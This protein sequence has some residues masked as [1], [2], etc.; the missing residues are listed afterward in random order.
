MACSTEDID[1][2]TCQIFG[3][4]FVAAKP[5]FL[6]KSIIADLIRDIRDP[7]RP[8]TLEQLNVV[9]ESMIR[10]RSLPSDE[11]EEEELWISISF[12]PTVPHCSLAT[13]IGLCIR[14]KLQRNLQQRF[15][16]DINVTEG[17]HFVEGDVNK[18][19]NDKERV[20][21]AMENPDLRALVEEC[22]RPVEY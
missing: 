5:R 8:E 9:S 16:L 12:T 14:V 11:G 22:I 15:K 19:I 6:L 3:K 2:V 4:L 17:T 20:A 18:Q 7:E 1:A 13:M 10:V 21:A